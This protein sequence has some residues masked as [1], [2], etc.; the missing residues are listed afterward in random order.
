VSGAGPHVAVLCGGVS[1][2]RDISLRSGSRIVDALADR[3]VSVTSIDVDASLLARLDGQGIDVALVAL[4]GAV[5]E[6]G[7]VPS[8]LALAGVPFSGSGALARAPARNKPIAQGLY[9]RAGLAVPANVTLSQH[10]LRELGAAG[11]MERI[12]ATL[13]TSLVVKPATG[14]SS[15]GVSVVEDAAGLL[16]AVVSALSYDDTVLI[17]RRIRGVEVAVAVLD[18]QPLPPIGIRPKDGGYDFA[19]RYT[20]GATE[21]DVPARLSEDVLAACRSAAV[22]AVESLGV[23]HLARADMIVDDEGR[24]W[25]LELDTS[26]GMTDTSLAPMAAEAA[27]IAFADLCLRL[28]ELALRDA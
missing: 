22:T 10:A 16:P 6:D 11:V 4:H 13:G 27:G 12:S 1:L 20:V 14:G 25:I 24:P 23:R 15:L 28:V 26:P 5:G 21:F 3:G 7:T 8:L 18:G 19:A 17:E 2:E 9:A